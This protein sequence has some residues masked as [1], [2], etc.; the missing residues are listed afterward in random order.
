MH[1]LVLAVLPI[2]IQSQD[3]PCSQTGCRTLPNLK[4]RY[5]HYSTVVS[6][7]S[8]L[9][10]GWYCTE[11][12]TML[13]KPPDNIYRCGTK[14][15]VWLQGPH[16][17]QENEEI[18]SEACL[19]KSKLEICKAKY[20]IK[21][22][23][24][25]GGYFVYWLVRTFSRS[26]YC[27]GEGVPGVVPKFK[28]VVTDVAFGIDT[29]YSL[30]NVP[31]SKVYFYCKFDLSAD[32]LLYRITWYQ[33]GTSMLVSEYGTT[34]LNES[35]KLTEN[36]FITNGFHLGSKL[37]CDAEAFTVRNGPPGPKSD[38]SNELFIGIKILTPRLEFK[39]NDRNQSNRTISLRVTIPI[40]CSGSD[41][42]YI[43]ILAAVPEESKFENCSELALELVRCG[44]QVNSSNALSSDINLT[45]QTSDTGQYRNED[46]FNRVYLKTAPTLEND[47]FNDSAIGHV[48][49]HI[50][51]PGT[52]LRDG[53]K[54]ESNN[55]PHMKTFD[56]HD[57]E[58]Q[59]TL[60]HLSGTY[61]LYK[62]EV[63]NSEVQLQVMK[64]NSD[65]AYC[66]CAVAAK[67]GQDI[68]IITT[69]NGNLAFEYK[70]C[71]DKQLKVKSFKSR[72]YKI[73]FPYGAFVEV[74]IQHIYRTL[75]LGVHVYPSVHDENETG[76]LCGTLDGKT[77][78]D[79]SK[80]DGTITNRDDFINEWR[81]KS[82]VENMLHKDYNFNNLTPLNLTLCFCPE[83][84]GGDIPLRDVSCDSNA[85]ATCYKGKD[86]S[87]H[88]CPPRG[89]RKRRSVEQNPKRPSVILSPNTMEKQRLK[90]EAE[91]QSWTR[92]DATAFCNSYLKESS[93]YKECEN[94]PNVRP[95]TAID[96]CI[97]DILLTNTTDW[98]SISWETMRGAC[99]TETDR[100]RTLWTSDG[101][102]PSVAENIKRIAC[103]NNC[104][105]AGLCVKGECHC[106]ENYGD[107]DCS[108]DLNIPPEVHGLLD[109]GLCDEKD[110][111]CSDAYIFAYPI[112]DSSDLKCHLKEFSISITGERT[113]I[114]DYIVEAEF[115]TI[116]EAV[117]SL[118][119]LKSKRETQFTDDS[120]VLGYGVAISND[121]VVFSDA[122]D[123]YKY[124]SQC[125][126]V[127]Y[128]NGELNFI[129][130]EGFCFIEGECIMNG[131]K[132]RSLNCSI[133]DESVSGFTWAFD[134][135]GE[136]CSGFQTT[137]ST[138]VDS[139]I[140]A[141]SPQ[142]EN[143]TSE[144]KKKLWIIGIVVPVFVASI[145]LVI[146]VIKKK[147]KPNRNMMR[148]P[149]TLRFSSVSQRRHPNQ[150]YLYNN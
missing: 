19:M 139:T 141:T 76:G 42:C 31:T 143:E 58:L 104:S 138:P 87:T 18:T 32:D 108:V 109:D 120:F 71:G 44:V 133:C 72:K 105:Q 117:C 135:A 57:Y 130:L 35:L 46:S 146:V 88:N 54:C 96:D 68:Y 136:G 73:F 55:D 37:S 29:T 34:N 123:L 82:S 112:I 43:E 84:R 85:I 79:F 144:P 134:N 150:F 102:S 119:N 113:H 121:G 49:V 91:I 60:R 41:S 12:I 97:A 6:Q 3:D 115:S 24:C 129:L 59:P 67:S 81:I 9:I 21:I 27:F 94:V 56:R 127:E 149:S 47:I 45:L 22:R 66:N 103:P 93:V 100:N 2:L 4:S 86:T 145:I 98:A 124:N 80:R 15:P 64:C 89:D 51:S 99:L 63:F 20:D 50:L 48:D 106:F 95:K 28:P 140:T 111:K 122:I 83:Y 74:T 77:D 101:N 26:A 132:S 116:V 16:P 33:D 110:L 61:V 10:T 13:D 39:Y 1:L 114:T 147:R 142:K 40:T 52:Q 53:A 30:E 90:R 14:F 126:G 23:K 62:N 128:R 125:Q 70:A 78:N 8:A 137:S 131:A 65:K 11:N 107:V 36:L 148:E 38:R 118:E 92:T 75:F 69:C 17:D 25:P 5:M 7:D